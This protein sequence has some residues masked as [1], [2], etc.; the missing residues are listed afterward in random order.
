MS[1]VLQ[2]R[3]RTLRVADVVERH[4]VTVSANE[5]MAA[6]AATL[7]GSGI[8]GAPVVDETGRCVGILS[9]GDFVRREAT[10]GDESSC[11]GTRRAEPAADAAQPTLPLDELGAQLVSA[12][13]TQAVQPISAEATLA[14]AARVMCAAHVHRLP[15]L[16]AGGVPVGMLT[17]LDIV[18]ALANAMD[19]AG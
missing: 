9:A 13:M 2:Q 6:A 12:H 18:A 11:V 10:R 7:L 4:I 14:Q 5:T 1:R 19:E 3:L 8:S 17:A 16:D 15:V